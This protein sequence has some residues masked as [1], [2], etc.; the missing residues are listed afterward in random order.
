MGEISLGGRSLKALDPD[1]VRKQFALVS[2]NS[3]FFNTTIRENLRL[4]RRSAEAEEI[5]AAARAAQI[6]E[7][8]ISLAKGYDTMIIGEQ[9]VRLSGGERQRLAIAR[10]LV[11][12][13]SIL[14]F[15]EPTANLDPQTEKQV[16][17]TLFAAM[18]GKT[19]LLITHRLIGLENVNEILVM[20]HGQIVERGTHLQL[21][22]QKG[23]YHRLWDLQNRILSDNPNPALTPISQI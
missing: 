10:A 3:S 11:K 18:R 20:D 23:L 21:L 15:D 1:E 16:L 19:A 22:M 13:A 12:D 6:H 14:M 2:Q 5:E 17:E 9:G 8:V 4:A 7:F